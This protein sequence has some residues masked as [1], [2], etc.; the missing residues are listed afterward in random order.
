[1]TRA[2]EMPGGR[3]DLTSQHGYSLIE[4]VVVMSIVGIIA[5]YAGAKWQ[6]DLTLYSKADEL[7]NDIREAQALAMTN[8]PGQY[9]IRTVASDSYRILDS[10][11]QPVDPQPK[12][13]DGVSI[14]AFAITFNSRG[15]PGPVTVN[16]QLAK[17]GQ[18]VTVRV[19]G[20]TGAAQR[21]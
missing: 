1:M 19:V 2:W 11:A 7:V 12:V 16:I 20:N 21:L 15:D 9:T 4:L 10:L 6:G 14:S 17:E 8:T 5:V 3:R 13:L 18:T